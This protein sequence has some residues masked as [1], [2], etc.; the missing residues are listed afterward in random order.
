MRLLGGT[1]PRPQAL[2]VITWVWAQAETA[3][4]CQRIAWF[5]CPAKHLPMK[6]F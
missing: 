3:P 2:I 4:I 5:E 1:T 6:V